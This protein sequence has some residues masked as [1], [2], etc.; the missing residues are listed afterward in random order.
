MQAREPV[1]TVG[2]QHEANE[3]TQTQQRL[4]D[5]PWMRESSRPARST[6]SASMQMALILHISASPSLCLTPV[7]VAWLGFALVVGAAYCISNT[8]T[9]RMKPTLYA[10]DDTQSSI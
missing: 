3:G 2:R 8:L 5:R 10:Y 9:I 4:D 6:A 1:T 7:Y